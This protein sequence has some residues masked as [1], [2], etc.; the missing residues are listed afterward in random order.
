METLG[1]RKEFMILF[2]ILG[3]IKELAD[4][5]IIFLLNYRDDLLEGRSVTR[6]FLIYVVSHVFAQS[7]LDV[8]VLQILD[9]RHILTRFLVVTHK[10]S[11]LDFAWL[12]NALILTNIF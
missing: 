11:A 9:I 4:L 10:M 12:I 6:I 5:N 3:L 2:R 7:T 1:M 8:N